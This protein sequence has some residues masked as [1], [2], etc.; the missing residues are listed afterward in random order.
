[1][2]DSIHS[3]VREA[4][5]TDF[6]I[7]RVVPDFFIVGAAKAGTTSLHHYLNQHPQVYLPVEE[8][9]P[10]FFCDLWG[11]TDPD[12]YSDIFHKAEPGQLIGESSTPY[13]TCQA[14][15]AWI[16]AANPDAKIVIALRNPADRAF[17]LYKQMV[18]Q[19]HETC[20]TFEQA[21]AAE[22]KRKD[23]LLMVPGY[24]HNY[25][26]FHSGLYSSQIRRYLNEFERS[27]ICF[28]LMDDLFADPHSVIKRILRTLE[29]SDEADFAP[30]VF[31]PSQYPR[32]VLLQHILKRIVE[33]G[34][35]R[36]RFHTGIRIANRVKRWNLR[37]GKD[38][39]FDPATRNSLVTRYREDILLTA[40]LIERDLS[41]WL[42]TSTK[43]TSQ[44]E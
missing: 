27:R 39:K 15:A 20:A 26:Y 12:R 21:L 31:N 13:L 41:Q 19:G 8:K 44:P 42:E 1:M 43:K 5:A 36:I 40:E 34:S 14:S 17:S 32:N 2:V 6:V 9:E 4:A 33:D 16:R 22:D 28:V 24:Y 30:E 29:V 35:R 10:G 37:K 3:D 18:K 7:P 25:L 23:G 38:P 11:Y